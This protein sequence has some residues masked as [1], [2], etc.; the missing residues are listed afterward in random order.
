M[1]DIANIRYITEMRFLFYEDDVTLLPGI[2]IL[3]RG[4]PMFTIY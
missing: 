2:Q 3:K 1:A 4:I